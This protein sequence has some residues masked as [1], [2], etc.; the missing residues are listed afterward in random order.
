MAITWSAN[1]TSHIVCSIGAKL[2]DSRKYSF[3]LKNENG[4]CAKISKYSGTRFSKKSES[5]PGNCRMTM[6]ASLR[7]HPG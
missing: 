5:K 6:T 3:Q 4:A 7:M 1:V 2:S